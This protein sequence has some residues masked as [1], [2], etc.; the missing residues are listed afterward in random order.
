MESIVYKI[1]QSG[2]MVALCPCC[3]P[4][5]VVFRVRKDGVTISTEYKNENKILTKLVEEGILSSRW[6]IK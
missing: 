3:V 2:W 4:E 6:K 1:G 5:G